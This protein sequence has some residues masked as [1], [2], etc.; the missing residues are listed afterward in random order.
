MVVFSYSPDLHD[1]SEGDSCYIAN[2][3]LKG[4]FSTAADIFS[5]G[6]SL[7]ELACDLELPSEGEGWH[8]LRKGHLPEQFIS[9][10]YRL[11]I[12]VHVHVCL[13]YNLRSINF[14]ISLTNQQITKKY[15]PISLYMYMYFPAHG[16]KCT[17]IKRITEFVSLEYLK[18]Y[19]SHHSIYMYM[20]M[21]ESYNGEC[22]NVHVHVHVVNHLKLILIITRK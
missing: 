20:Y 11:P 15:Y 14:V 8:H 9:G 19:G 7:L 18:L 16:G 21:Y 3:L 4:K 1:A 2:E 5:L 22:S 13:M 10:M 6:I 12:H 17:E